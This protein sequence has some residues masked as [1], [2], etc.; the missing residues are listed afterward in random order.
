GGAASGRDASAIDQPSSRPARGSVRFA[1]T[2]DNSEI[3]RVVPIARRKW[4]K[5]RVVMSLGPGALPTFHRNDILR[6]SAEVQVTTTCVVAGPRCIGKS[7]GFSPREDARIVLANRRRASG[8]AHTE[9][10]ANTHSVRCHQQRPQ[11][12]HHCVLVFPPEPTRIRHPRAL[13][14]RPSACHLNL[15]LEAD[16]RPAHHGQVVLVGEDTPGGSIRQDKGRLNA[17]TLHEHVSPPKRYRTTNVRSHSIPIA[18]SGKAGRR[19]VYSQR[20]NNLRKGDVIEAR[21]RHLVTIASLPYPA[22]VGTDVILAT[23]PRSVSPT[24]VAQGAVSTSGGL[25]EA[26]GFNCT[27]GASAYSSPCRTTKAGAARIRH[28]IARNGHPTPL[29]V[30][31]VCAGAPKRAR[32]RPNDAMHVV[33][34]GALVVRRYRVR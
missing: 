4:A 29:Y 14:C 27:H 13:P 20:I 5:K 33:S 8:G 7:Y 12:N 26:N 30:N 23:G 24:G 11:R 1:T 17:I 28:T 31:V 21:A 10:I 18:P 15:V 9:V 25:T 3:E 32:A 16:H 2:G 22:F 6:T 34:G 19:V